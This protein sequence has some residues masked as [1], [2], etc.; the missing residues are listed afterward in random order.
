MNRCAKTADN[1][2]G[3][4]GESRFPEADNL[5][6]LRARYYAS[7]LGRFLSRDP[8]GYEYSM[9]LYEY[10][11]NNLINR[12]DSLGLFPYTAPSPYPWTPPSPSLGELMMDCWREA[13]KLANW[14]ATQPWYGVHGMM[15]CVVACELAKKQDSVC[16]WIAGFG[17]KAGEWFR[18][19][20]RD[21]KTEAKGRDCAKPCSSNQSCE[22]CCSMDD[23]H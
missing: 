15:H 9:N 6:Y 13:R 21:R 22:E 18:D 3:F 23:Y 19:Y 2:Y 14:A 1:P 7:A 12:S 11:T 16:A 10:V 17:H 5:I 8:I 20:P 4:T